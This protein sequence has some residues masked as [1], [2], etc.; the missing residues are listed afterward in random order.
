VAGNQRRT[1]Y[2]RLLRQTVHRGVTLARGGRGDNTTVTGV[3]LAPQASIELQICQ[4]R[5]NPVAQI[6]PWEQ[7]WP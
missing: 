3:Q 1:G 7:A 2:R 6:Y 4:A 5:P